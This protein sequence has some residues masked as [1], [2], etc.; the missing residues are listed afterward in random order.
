MN[1]IR[2]RI[3]V[4]AQDFMRYYKR[5]FDSVL[6]TTA[7]SKIIQ[8]PAGALQKFVDRSGVHGSFRVIYDN[9]NKLVRIERVSN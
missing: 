8:L 4:S 3:A 9:N 5:E 7:D 1:E 2:F 6:V